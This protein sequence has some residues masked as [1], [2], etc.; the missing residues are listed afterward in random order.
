[1]LLKQIRKDTTESFNEHFVLGDKLSG[2]HGHNIKYMAEY[3]K[4]PDISLPKLPCVN[5]AD[6]APEQYQEVWRYGIKADERKEKEIE[7]SLC[8]LVLRI[9]EEL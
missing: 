8:N 6:A 7:Q 2:R 1:M 9:R 4:I 3:L 5:R